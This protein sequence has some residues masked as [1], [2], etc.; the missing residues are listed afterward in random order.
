MYRSYT[1]GYLPGEVLTDAERAACFRAGFVQELYARGLALGDAESM[2][3]EAGW[4]NALPGIGDVF[5]TAIILGV[6]IGFVSHMVGKTSRGNDAGNRK[7]RAELEYYRDTVSG[8]R[9]RLAARGGGSGDDDDGG[10]DDEDDGG[11]SGGKGRSGEDRPSDSSASSGA[12][13]SKYMDFGS[14]AY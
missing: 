11:G 1:M 12:G 8:I 13:S 2:A 4:V 6:P 5:R 7:M 9:N 3:K 10:D 14:G